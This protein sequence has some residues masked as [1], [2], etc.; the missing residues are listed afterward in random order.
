VRESYAAALEAVRLESV[1]EARCW[2]ATVAHDFNNL[3]AA[4]GLNC[5]R[6]ASDAADAKQV[7]S[8]V[9]RIRSLQQFARGQVEDLLVLGWSTPAAGREA[10]LSKVVVEMLPLLEQ[11]CGEKAR[12]YA[13][14]DPRAGRVAMSSGRVR[15][16]LLNLVVNAR[17]AVEHNGRI[18][19]ETFR[20]RIARGECARI[21]LRVWD[22]GKG[23]DRAA[24]RG[25]QR[26]F[27]SSKD[28]PARGWGLFTVRRAVAEAGGEV[29]IESNGKGTRITVL[30]PAAAQGRS[31]GSGRAARTQSDGKRMGLIEK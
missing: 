3:L 27:F 21:G 30:L 22:N 17:D 13:T 25:I 18:G 19:I 12:V 8:L 14:L 23:M 26:L 2:V 15:Q 9:E 1:E 29:R 10:R 31:R 11:L 20:R 4:I 5:D 16:V 28:G 7:R 6:I 24:R